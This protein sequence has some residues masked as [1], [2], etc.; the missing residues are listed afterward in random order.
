MKI[1]ILGF[2]GAIL[3]HRQHLE[4]LG[5]AVLDVRYPEQLKELDGIILPGGVRAPR[6]KLLVRTG[7]LEPL[8]LKIKE[9]LPVWGTCAGM[10]LLA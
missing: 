6:G 2:Q 10:I 8:R 1:G 4:K 7:I 5:H 3:E 9:G